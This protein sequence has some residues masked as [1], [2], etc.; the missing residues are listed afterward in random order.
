MGCYKGH[1]YKC[2]IKKVPMTDG[3]ITGTEYNDEDYQFSKCREIS[4]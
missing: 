1:I 2:P 4:L 3:D